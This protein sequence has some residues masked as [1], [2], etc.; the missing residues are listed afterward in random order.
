MKAMEA[1]YLE[2]VKLT[3]AILGGIGLFLLAIGMMTDGLKLAAGP[4]LR[5]LLSKWSQTPLRGIFSGFFMTAIVQSSSAVTVASLGFVNAGLINMRQALGIIYGANVG[6]TMTGWLV[7]LIGFNLN[8]QAFALPMIG[9]GMLIKLFKQQGRFASLGLALVGFGLLFLGIEILKGAFESLVLAFDI[10]KVTADGIAGIA[11]FLLVGIVMTIM[12]QSSSASIALTITAASSGVVG[13]YAAAAMVVGANVGT[14]STA[15]IASIGATSNA[16]RV[17]VAQVIFNVVT[18]CVALAIL[19]VLFFLIEY[20][21][22]YLGLSMV[23]A[24]SLALFHTVF[25]ILGVVLVYPQNERLATFL[26][27]RFRTWDEKESHPKYIDKTI[28]KIPA[29]AVNALLLELISISDKVIALFTTAIKADRVEIAAF[30][31]KVKVIKLLSTEVSSFIVSIESTGMADD[32]SDNLTTLMR[33]DQYFVSCTLCTERIFVYLSN[34]EEISTPVLEAEMLD[35]FEKISVYMKSSRMLS[36][37]QAD[38]LV[39]DL[40][41]LQ[42]A[43]DGLKERL[44]LEGTR[45]RISV[46]QMSDTIDSL[47]EAIRLVQQWFKAVTRL[48]KLQMEFSPSNGGAGSPVTVPD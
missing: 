39:E 19:P 25:N 26:E 7:A 31:S 45:S 43:H 22:Q 14:T 40:A 21:S 32:T 9:I 33:V 10:T 6:T 28:A 34:R 47:A 44:I 24:I 37:N 46:A 41:E 36:V 20:V 15:L 30:E 3:G 1:V 11:A 23:P 48:Q 13:L 17:A 27:N 8:I 42:L 38:T 12:T 16:K 2:I 29:L 35:F 4:A 18:A 5:T